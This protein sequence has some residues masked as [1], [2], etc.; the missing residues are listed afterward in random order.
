MKYKILAIFI[1]TLFLVSIGA[2]AIPITDSL[3]KKQTSFMDDDVPTWN[4]GHQWIYDINKFLV[5]VNAS[6]QFIEL[7]LAVNDLK[8]E[9]TSETQTSYG[10]DI[11][12]KISGTFYYDDGAGITL[13]GSLIFTSLNGILNIRKADLAAQRESIKIRS[14]ALLTNHPLPINIPIPLPLTITIEVVQPTPRPILDFPLVDGKMGLINGSNI[15]ANIKVES[16]VL[17][18]LSI[19]NP[20]IPPEIIF[21]QEMELPP[22]LYSA[23]LEEVT[24]PAGVFD[25]YNIL[26][27]EGLLGSVYY[28]PAAGSI[29]K[30]QALLDIPDMLFLDFEG[31]LQ[32]TTYP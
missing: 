17:K 16:I 8:L 12:G 5:Q 32:S 6:G 23:T 20:D 30:A 27:Y 25:A 3:L 15:S 9:V 14:I 13:G 11:S 31:K 1:T 28:S 7:S 26:F 21:D 22:L 19:I 4:L 24:V 18:I 2:S 10:V 29:I